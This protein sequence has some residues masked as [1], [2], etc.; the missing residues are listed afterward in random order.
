MRT[1]TLILL[2]CLAL[3]GCA[4]FRGNYGDRFNAEDIAALQKGVTTRSEVAAR[5]GA[6]DRVLQ[7]NG[8]DV[9]QYYQYELKSGTILFFS[10]TNVKGQDVYVF[11]TPAGVVDE[12]IYGK[13]KPP[14]KFQ[15]WPFGE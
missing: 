4:F 11:F 2:V 1:R 15:W 3:P 6:P 13:P 12:V 10:R 8:R 14:P 7:I 9:F 5:L